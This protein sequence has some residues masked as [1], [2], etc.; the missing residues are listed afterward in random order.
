MSS[1]VKLRIDWC[2]FKAAEYAVKHWHY[3][4][5]MP[6]S[7]TV[8]IGVWEDDR[9]V[10]AVI[11]SWGANQNLGAQWNLSMTQCC[12]LTRIALDRHETPVTRIVAIALKMLKKQSPG[13]QLVV[14]YAD[15][16]EGHHGG[17]YAGGGWVYLGKVQLNGGTPKFLIRGKLM[18][19]RSVHAR[20]GAG[21]QNIAFLHEHIDPF[22]QVVYTS[23]K[24]KYVYPLNTAMRAVVLP[25][26]QPYPKR[27]EVMNIE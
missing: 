4:R 17:I 20:W 27:P 23:G 9:F 8:K 13:V 19:G 25:L 14:S 18:H 6:A 10:G 15:C 5:S 16:D 12:E 3:S 22:A 2:N 7:K 11:F 26:A 21:A 24:H 1:S